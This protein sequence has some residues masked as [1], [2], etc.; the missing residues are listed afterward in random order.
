M[1]ATAPQT[2]DPYETA[3]EQAIKPVAVIC[4]LHLRPR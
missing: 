1:L 2:T 4:A 3:T